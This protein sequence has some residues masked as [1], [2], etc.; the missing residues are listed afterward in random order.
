MTRRALCKRLAVCLVLGAV[1]TVAVAWGFVYPEPE[2]GY[3]PWT[4]YELMGDTPD[5]ATTHRLYKSRSA[6]RA[7]YT[8]RWQVEHE[9]GLQRWRPIEE[10]TIEAFPKYWGLSRAALRSRAMSEYPRTTQEHAFGW[11]FLSMWVVWDAP[12]F[13]GWKIAG[14]IAIEDPIKENPW[15]FGFPRGTGEMVSYTARALPLYPIWWGFLLNTLFFGSIFSPLVFGPS[16]WRERRRRSRG[17]CPKCS[18]DLL[19]DLD[20][21]CPEC[22]WGKGE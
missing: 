17:R 11:P 22:G 12:G 4:G 14:G 19:V 2:T 16:I 13:W 10:S 1:T 8:F 6:G 18:Y 7:V 15:M 5:E 3:R 21:G 9:Y 20:A